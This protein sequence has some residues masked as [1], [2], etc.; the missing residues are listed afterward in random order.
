MNASAKLRELNAYVTG[1]SASKRVVVWDTTIRRMS[2]DEVL[3]VTG[4]EMGHYVLGHVRDGIFFACAVLLFF[5]YLAYRLLHWMLARWGETW[6]IRGPDDLASL[7]V[8]I[9]LLSVF[10]FLF[11]P[12]IQRIQ[13]PPR[14]SGRSVRSR[15]DPRFDSG[16]ARGFSARVS[17]PG[18][19]GSRRAQSFDRREI[20]VLQSSAARRAHALRPN[21]RPVVPGRAPEFVRCRPVE[22]QK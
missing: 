2:P 3:F 9:L 11:T 12:I 18:R 6:A 4:H 14:A 5:L 15:S 17:N 1:L 7:P 16:R 10:G 20:L 13:P 22:P 21:V 8:L 19:S